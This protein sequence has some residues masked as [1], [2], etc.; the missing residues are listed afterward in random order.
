MRERFNEYQFRGARE[1]ARRISD[2][3]LLAASRHGLKIG[4]RMCFLTTS[5]AYITTTL[6]SYHNEIRI[7]NFIIS[8]ALTGA[9]YD[10]YRG[11]GRMLASAVILCLT[12]G[13]P[14]GLCCKGY[15]WIIGMDYPAYRRRYHDYT[16]ASFAKANARRLEWDQKWR[17]IL[18]GRSAPE[19]SQ[20]KVL[21]HDKL[22][23]DLADKGLKDDSFP[24]YADAPN[25]RNVAKIDD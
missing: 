22:I 6:T 16:D 21:D 4:V 1:Y 10:F 13:L 3:T 19:D 12:V 18:Y 8:S 11:P 7:S 2:M 25:R 23:A 5:W 14:L 15:L 24:Q 20:T 17:Q 9:A